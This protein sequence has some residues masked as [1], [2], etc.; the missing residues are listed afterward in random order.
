MSQHAKSVRVESSEHIA[1]ATEELEEQI[2]EEKAKAKEPSTKTL[3]DLI[4][5]RRNNEDSSENV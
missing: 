2:A 4:D 1:K 5:A 3:Q